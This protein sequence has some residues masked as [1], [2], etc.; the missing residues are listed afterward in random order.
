MGP[1]VKKLK[2]S[3]VDLLAFGNTVQMA[4]AIFS[5]DGQTYLCFLPSSKDDAEHAV[6]EMGTEDWKKMMAQVDVMET[7][8]LSQAED[9]TLTKVIVRKSQ[10]AVDTACTWKVFKR[11]G[12][13]CRYCGNDDTPLTVDHLVCWEAGGPSIE[14]NMVSSCRKCNKT[15]GNM[16]YADWL[17]HPRYKDLSRKLTPQ[18]RKANEDLADTLM[19]IPRLYHKRSR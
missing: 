10:R 8:I 4:G 3:D 5:G 16:E 6:L 18:Q 13:A 17:R 2:L 15:R 12:Y 11:D 1:T 14:A 19:A 7:E 9:G